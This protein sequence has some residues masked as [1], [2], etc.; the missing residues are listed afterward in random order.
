MYN[1]RN[2]TIPEIIYG[3]IMSDEYLLELYS[4]L[5]KAYT[6]KLF[7]RTTEK[8]DNKRL[9][10][11][12]RFADILSKSAET[13]QSGMHKIWSQQIIALLDKLYPNEYKIK[14][15]KHSI[16]LAC[17]N[18]QGI[19]ND[20]FLRKNASD[21]NEMFND[22]IDISDKEYFK[23]PTAEDQ[24]FFEDQKSIFDGFAH[25][26][27]SYSAPTSMGKSYVMRVFIKQQ[28]TAGSTANFA[29]IVPTKALINEVKSKILTDLGK[30]FMQEHNYKV[31]VSANDMVLEQ[32]HNFIF[33]MTPER[34]L[35]LMNTF[36]ISIEY[37]F[38]DEAHKISTKDTRSPFYY[39]MVDKISATDPKP[40]VIFSS[41]N[42]PNPEI[43]LD[44]VPDDEG[45]QKKQAVYSPVCQMK[46]LINLKDGVVKA[47]N[48]YSKEFIKM[49]KAS[50]SLRLPILINGVSRKDEQNIIYCGTIQETIEL[51]VEYAAP[52]TAVQDPKKKARLEAISKAI[53]NEINADYFLVDLIKKGVAFHVGYLPASI[54][55]NIEDAFK[56]QVIT[57]LFCTSTLIEGVNLP[58]DNLFIT[59]CKNGMRDLDDVS[60]RNLIGRVG[61]IDHS[62]FGNVFMVCLTTSNDNIIEKY[63]D[64]LEKGVSPQKLSIAAGL[65]DAQK[66]AII[67]SLVANDFEMKNRP[68]DTTLDEFSFMRKQALIFVR[69][70]KSN[71]NSCV[72]N[73]LRPYASD[74]EICQI[75]ENAK[76]NPTIK[77]LDV[78][79]DQIITLAQF[80]KR[81]NKYPSLCNNE[82]SYDSALDF[83]F[84]LSKV[85]KWRIYEKKTLGYGS[86]DDV[87][88]A[89]IKMYTNILHRWMSG[90][91]LSSIILAAIRY[92]ENHASGG[93]WLNNIK[94]ADTYDKDDPKHKNYVIA[95]TLNIIENVVL[96][97]I[98]NYFREF[99]TEY[100]KQHDNQP[101]DND[102]YEYVEFGTTNELT[103][104]LQRYGYSREASTY[105]IKHIAEFIDRSNPTPAFPFM[106]RKS[107]LLECGNSD[108]VTETPEIHI[109]VPE[110]FIE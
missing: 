79:P 24:F 85:F 3:D 28:I 18:I 23:V 100:K 57:T 55:K 48:D 50:P 72:V 107:A 22:L 110:L 1:P 71:R 43:Y 94:I 6:R 16:L 90:H 7:N 42:I 91:G 108:V 80:I 41:P 13:S 74:D 5:L 96:F 27:F 93:L 51:A 10:D 104:V 54:R 73:S 14:F 34:F 46:Y 19:Q 26:Y 65:K 88:I 30:D 52:L 11:L 84:A 89:R 99:S 32:D 38:I 68:K 82:I 40:H 20:D 47:Y 109:N 63:Q 29:I 31:V 35:Y 56:E 39:E 25:Q 49:G 77:G 106:L 37:L 81:G 36:N 58:A 70:L 105:I 98:A 9:N 12:L 97:S 66:R 60:F 15:Y 64:L 92:R 78:S 83:M 87:N 21:F 17:N 44:L 95:D 53:K 61:R 76:S 101:F 86:K 59:S 103:I 45:K 33:I 2:R 69:D 67:T 62:L 4:D 8:F 75:L 102:W